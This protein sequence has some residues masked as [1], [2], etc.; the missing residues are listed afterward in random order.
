MVIPSRNDVVRLCPGTPNQKLEL[1]RD[2]LE[3]A[4]LDVV[5]FI[6]DRLKRLQ[7]WPQFNER[8]ARIARTQCALPR[9]AAIWQFA[10]PSESELNPSDNGFRQA[11]IRIAK[12]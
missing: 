4:S 10:V 2:R 5:V 11:G 1:E 8:M 3:C 6:P 7:P 9:V 12:I